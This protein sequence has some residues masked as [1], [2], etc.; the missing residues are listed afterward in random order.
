MG[1]EGGMGGRDIFFA[2]GG[3]ADSSRLVL[4]MY[5]IFIIIITIFI[6]SIIISK[7]NC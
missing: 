6:S 1:R 7:K 2:F 4:I 5:P 3:D